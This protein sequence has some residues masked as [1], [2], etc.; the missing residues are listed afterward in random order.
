VGRQVSPSQDS[1]HAPT[2]HNS[3]LNSTS[4][5]TQPNPSSL[6]Q[7]TREIE[8]V[9]ETRRRRKRQRRGEE[10]PGD[11]RIHSPSRSPSRSPSPSS[12][13]AT[14][15][16]AQCSTLQLNPKTTTTVPG[17]RTLLRIFIFI[18]LCNSPFWPRS[19]ASKAI[20]NQRRARSNPTSMG[21]FCP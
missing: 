1:S 19:C 16:T 15:S 17:Q 2:Q 7:G 6:L 21:H 11:P 10:G 5:P 14:R 4:S 13:T 3:Q 9:R 12:T 8:R 20:I 18:F